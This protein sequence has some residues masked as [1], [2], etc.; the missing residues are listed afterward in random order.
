MSS[1]KKLGESKGWTGYS[2][3]T[4]NG[5]LITIGKGGFYHVHT[6]DGSYKKIKDTDWSGCFLTGTNS[7]IM[8]INGNGGVWKIDYNTGNF[9][10]LSDAKWAGYVIDGLSDCLLAIGKGGIF[11]ITEDGKFTQLSKSDWSGYSCCN[12]YRSLLYAAGP[13]GFYEIN[14]NDGS[15]KKL[16][17]DNWTGHKLVSN[18]KSTIVALN[19]TGN[20]GVF[21]LTFYDGSFK[22]LSTSNWVGYSMR[23]C[24]GSIY[25]IGEGG[26]YQ[27]NV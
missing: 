5:N 1:S 26:I 4:Y 8:A 3:D 6:N 27:L 17:G 13:G 21:L 14:S 11:K 16:S 15:S 2:L 7:Q 10:K 23:C 25:G 19:N 12:V 20:G 9:T 22:K 18:D 24:N